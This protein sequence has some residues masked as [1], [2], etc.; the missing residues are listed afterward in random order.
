[1]ISNKLLQ[2]LQEGIIDVKDLPQVFVSLITNRFKQPSIEGKSDNKE[3]TKGIDASNLKN[4]K[5]TTFTTTKEGASI[6]MK[7]LPETSPLQIL[8][9]NSNKL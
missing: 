8:I 9:N 2:L 5:L 6:D 7:Y 1:M 3:L 4:V